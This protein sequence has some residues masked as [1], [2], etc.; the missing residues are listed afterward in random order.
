MDIIVRTNGEGEESEMIGDKI[1]LNLDDLTN[2]VAS[3]NCSSS[4]AEN[5][6]MI[7]LV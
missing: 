7:I 3:C 1:N 2:F 6:L 4:I 5:I